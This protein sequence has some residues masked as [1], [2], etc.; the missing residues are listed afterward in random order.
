MA[1]QGVAEFGQ[2]D[3]VETVFHQGRLAID[4]LRFDLDQRRDRPDKCTLEFLRQRLIGLACRRI[5]LIDRGNR[6]CRGSLLRLA[7]QYVTDARGFTGNDH[8]LVQPTGHRLFQGPYAT[9]ARQGLH[10]QL[11]SQHV[12]RG[13]IHLHA[14]LIP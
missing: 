6:Q 3:G 1:I 12:T 4:V 5:A 7:Q 11:L 2:R 8:K 13:G 10:A 14:T 9:V